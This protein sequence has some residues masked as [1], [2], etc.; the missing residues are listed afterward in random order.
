M[1]SLGGVTPS[2]LPDASSELASAFSSLTQTLGGIRDSGSAEAAVSSLTEVNRNIASATTRMSSLGE[3]GKAILRS[4]VQ[5]A[6]PKLRSVV[7][8]VMARGVLGENAK[9]ILN[10]ILEKLGALAA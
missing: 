6:L 2:R 1:A 8:Q 10:D 7:D 5:S 9:A 3:S 4:L